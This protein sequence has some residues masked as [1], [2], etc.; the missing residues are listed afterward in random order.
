MHF[1]GI[2][3]DVWTGLQLQATTSCFSFGGGGHEARKNMETM[4]WIAMKF[5]SDVVFYFH[6]GDPLTLKVTP[7]SGQ[8]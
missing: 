3:D 6:S 1:K 7:A 8:V 5:S 2:F 4:E